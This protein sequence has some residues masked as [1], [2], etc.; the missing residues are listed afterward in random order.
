MQE[1]CE[2][3]QI[4]SIGKT[5][6]FSI[7]ERKGNKKGT[8]VLSRLTVPALENAFWCVFR[9]WQRTFVPLNLFKVTSHQHHT[10][11]CVEG[12]LFNLCTF[13]ALSWHTVTA[14][15]VIRFEENAWNDADE[16]D[17]ERNFNDD[18]MIKSATKNI[19][20]RRGL[21]KKAQKTALYSTIDIL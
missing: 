8:P 21:K 17:V 1:Q 12:C 11:F 20:K 18:K 4:S 13:T 10:N 19:K 5:E 3:M 2:N 7:D 14:V 9:G 15:C 6:V 16:K